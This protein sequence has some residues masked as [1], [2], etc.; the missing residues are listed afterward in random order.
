MKASIF[1]VSFV[2]LTIELLT[3]APGRSQGMDKEITLGLQKESL[4]FALNKIEDLSGF[5]IAYAIGDVEKYTGISLPR[6]KRT[7]EK[8][9]ELVLAQTILGFRTQNDAIIIYQSPS[10]NS[11]NT[12]PVADTIRG[13]VL[14][15]RNEPVESASIQVKGSQ[16]GTTTNARG[17][18]V[19]RDAGPRATIVV[20]AVGYGTQEVSLGGRSYIDLQLTGIATGMEEVVVTALGISRKTKSLS[21]ATQS[22]KPSTLTE[23]RDPN[24]VLNSLQGKI[25]NALITQSSGGLG[26][27]AKVILRGNRSITGNSSAL[28]V[29]DGIPGGDPGI[30]PDNI[31][32]MTILTGSAGA[33]LYGSEAGNGVIVITTKKGRKDGITVGLNSGITAERP[34]ALPRVQ[35]TYGQGT[36]GNMDI[37]VGDSWGAKVTGQSYTDHLGDQSSYSAQPDNIKDFF[38][39]GINL[40]NAISVSGGSEKAQ[41][42]LSYIN[43]TTQG[44]IPNNNL[45]SH[46]VNLRITNQISKNF[47]TDAKV[48]YHRRDIKASPRAGEANTPVMDIY[49]IPRN[50]STAMAKHYQDINNIGVPV[51]A[52]WPST[53]AGVYANPYWEVNNDRLDKARNS[54]IGFLKA[55][56]QVLSWL[57]ISASANIDS[58]S[59]MQEQKTFQGTVSWARNAGGYYSVS[60]TNYMQKWF[61]LM[62]EGNN[63]ITKDLSINY[64]AGAIYKDNKI[65]NAVGIANGLNVTNKFSMNLATA[66]VSQQSGNEV[67][68]QSVFA[69]ASLS[70]KDYLFLEGSFR[71]DWDSRLPAP[72][73]F[74]YY[75]VGLSGILSDMIKLPGSMNYLKAFVSYA[76]V[77]NGGQ[78]GL[79]TTPY[80]YVAGT[81]QGYLYRRDVLPFPTLKPEIV[82]SIEAGIDARF[83]DNRLGFSVNYYKSNSFN[84]LFTLQLPVGTGY[85]TSYLNAGNIQNQGIEV[86][87]NGSPVRQKKFGWDISFNF[88]LNRNKVIELTPQIQSIKLVGYTDFGGQPQINV[89]GS[90]GDI[91]AHTWLK[92][93]KGQ[94]LVTNDG[95]PQTSNSV[96][97][98]PSLVGNFNP[99]AR[100]GLSNTLHYNKFSLR[101]LVDGRIGGIMISGTEMN[102]SFSGITEE[103]EKYRDGGLNLA[104]VDASGSPVTQTISA[105]QFWRTASGKRYGTGEFYTYDATNFRIRELSLGYDIP[106][107]HFFIKTARISAVGRNLLWLYRG[108]SK[109]DI[110]GL[111]KRKMWMDPDM[112]L[113]GGNGLTGVEYGAFP[114]TRSFGINVQLTF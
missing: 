30:N 74:S 21:Y 92:N 89:G 96:G 52:P 20:S 102:L 9:L 53:A 44:I 50:V 57:G 103:T 19:L 38:R 11:G 72:H 60:N 48:T 69:L 26:S 27:E 36:N 113:Y 62:V 112:S 32:S 70:L 22:V 105:Q 110:P 6:A 108:S 65:D 54:I 39:T 13:K 55:K 7:V 114:S 90:F 16:N 46:I 75:S 8:T 43:N 83:F 101:V 67:Q 99:K 24:N 25:A 15:D 33:A 17:E 3:A 86:I 2:L 76:E 34:F 40:N 37:T 10:S 64:H 29:I 82:R 45:V 95:R 104:G 93:D 91:F 68:V 23:V 98:L 106:V 71:N 18:F 88:G 73:S 1:A 28:I 42:F 85:A 100:I 81:G 4:S 97:D 58:Y 84:Q 94:Y 59:E 79:L 5:R 111:G 80:D 51:P 109:L 47:S 63:N 41:T 78:F 56:Y 49:Q 31:E 66:P 14:N 61:D 107:Q 87:V 77:G 35:N 12:A